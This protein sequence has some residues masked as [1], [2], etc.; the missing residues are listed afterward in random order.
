LTP[1]IMAFEIIGMILGL[2]GFSFCFFG[3][4][5]LFAF[6]EN[7][8]IGGITATALFSTFM[9]IKTGAI[10]AILA[11]NVFRIV[12]VIIGLLAFLRL[13]R[14]RW[15]SRYTTSV[16]TG[17]GLGITFGL[18]IRTWVMNAV[19][20]T[21]T[22]IANRSPDP[23]SAVLML[24]ITLT[25]TTYFLYSMKFSGVF[26]TGRLK[27]VATLGFIF[28]YATFGYLFAKILVNEAFDSLGQYLVQY[29]YQPIAD[30]KVFL[31][32]I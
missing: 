25:V 7:L 21:V 16:L 5:N 23:Y 1:Y 15:A 6:A 19:I 2:F 4:N 29:L 11:G 24:I 3:D 8:Y 28:L 13:T 30:L 10:D 9:S 12:P 20:A 17:V 18:T 26:H 31:G 32:I 27:Y 22:A 14:Y